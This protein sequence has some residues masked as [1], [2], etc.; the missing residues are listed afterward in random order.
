[1]DGLFFRCYNQKDILQSGKQRTP[2]RT[3][4]VVNFLLG[5][6]IVLLGHAQGLQTNPITGEITNLSEAKSQ[7]IIEEVRFYEPEGNVR[8]PY[9]RI[10]GSPFWKDEFLPAKIFTTTGQVYASPIRLNLVTSEIHF[11]K[12]G[13]EMVLVD[14]NVDKI[15][16]SWEHDSAL[17]LANVSAL[18]LNNKKENGY[19]QVLNP[20]YCQLLKYTKRIVSSADSL[21][22]TQK[23]YFFTDE[24]TYFLRIIDK[25]EK[26]KR[27][28]KENIT[29][30][31][32][33]APSYDAW[34]E[35]NKI[36]FKKE[37]DVVRFLNHYNA[38]HTM[39]Q[40]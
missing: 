19:I 5:N 10:K 27:L 24:L 3:C 28:N 7:R 14:G 33:S 22:R 29:K 25:T 39:K 8:L 15:V 11:V 17:F 26:V 37:D 12:N 23:R 13:E 36:D 40:D 1:M 18:L 34:I 6:F 35:K 4:S 31:L 38:T 30:L 16:F 21:F 9:S 32:P 20:G 2:M